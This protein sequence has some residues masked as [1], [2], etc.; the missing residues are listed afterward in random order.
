MGADTWNTVA[1]PERVSARA[2]AAVSMGPGGCHLSTY[3]RTPQGYAQ[4]GWHAADGLH[5]VLAHRAA[6]EGKRG[7]VPVGMTLDHTCKTKACVNVDHLR[8]LTNHD[9]ARRN[10]GVDFPLGQCVNGHGDE[11]LRTYTRSGGKKSLGCHLCRADYQ[12]RYRD[13]KAAA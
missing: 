2:L 13:R 8:V 4:L 1:V 3:S 9:N 7:P 11:H 5:M 6:W 10:T 12:R